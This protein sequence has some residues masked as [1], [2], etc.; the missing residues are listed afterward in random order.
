MTTSS[1]LQTQNFKNKK[2]KLRGNWSLSVGCFYLAKQLFSPLDTFS[3]IQLAVESRR[4]LY[5]E[6]ENPNQSPRKE[7]GKMSF[8]NGKIEIREQ[9]PKTD[10][11]KLRNKF[12]GWVVCSS[13]RILLVHLTRSLEFTVKVIMCANEL[14][15]E[16]CVRD[17]VSG[18]DFLVVPLIVVE[19]MLK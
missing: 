18:G 12:I 19:N 10:T 11:I 2:G 9:M 1:P 17:F 6:F 14:F 8:A 13:F 4:C 3:S 15:L 7:T 16:R 5:F